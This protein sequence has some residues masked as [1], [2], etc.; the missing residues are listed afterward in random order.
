MFYN[1]CR[2]GQIS[3]LW[4]WHTK[5]G[6]K[7]VL[8][9]NQ[10]T[11]VFFWVYDYKKRYLKIDEKSVQNS[12]SLTKCFNLKN[13]YTKWCWNIFHDKS[14]LNYVCI[15]LQSTSSFMTNEPTLLILGLLVPMWSIPLVN[16]L[17]IYSLLYSNITQIDSS[18]SF[19]NL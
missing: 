19:V 13:I 18:S 4:I 7:F 2:F 8:N 15:I 14:Q 10:L 11:L 12:V 1:W 17:C 3:N 9:M 6:S 16:I 5:L